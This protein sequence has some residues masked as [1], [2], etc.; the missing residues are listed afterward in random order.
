MTDNH[1][2]TRILSLGTVNI[3][4][5]QTVPASIEITTPV[6]EI[7]NDVFLIWPAIQVRMSG[8]SYD[9]FSCDGRIR[10]FIQEISWNMLIPFLYSLVSKV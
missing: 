5:H 8:H 9:A 4:P 3:T 2:A 1:P 6:F 7:G 10:F